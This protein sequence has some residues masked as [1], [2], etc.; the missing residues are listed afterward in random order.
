M[1][2]KNGQTRR[3]RL[4]TE[5][6]QRQAR[7]QKDARGRLHLALHRDPESGHEHLILER[8]VFQEPWQN[9][10]AAATAN[11]AHGLLQGE[12]TLDRTLALARNVMA[13][14][15]RLAEGFLS[16]APAGAVACKAGCDHCCYQVVGVTAPE[17]LA[18]A[19]HLK[20]TLSPE[21]L[22]KVTAHIAERQLQTRGL[23]SNER[24]SPDHPCA[25][26]QAGRCS[27]YEVRPLSC[28]GM[29]SL[30]ANECAKRLREP[31][32]RAEFLA[33]GLGG[34]SFLEP[35]RAFHA[36]SAGLQL[37]LSEVYQLDMQPL[38]LTA[39]LHLLLTGPES[40]ARDWLDGQSSFRDARGGDSSNDPGI[41]ELSGTV[42][43]GA[44]RS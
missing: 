26:L 28:R 33:K 11:T 18:I 24:F 30:D 3:A 31:E 10:I 19:A 40:I 4:E 22:A 2:R 17:A 34:H 16:H 23:S 1:S 39:A 15:S 35:I 12:P 14:T 13:A 37:S 32:A 38:E 8:A 41:R 44:T 7:T 36:V 43:L 6:K 29:N 20:A 42:T 5:R 9:E 21:E 25:F 27:I